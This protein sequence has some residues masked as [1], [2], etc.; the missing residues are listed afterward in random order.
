MKNKQLTFLFLL[1]LAIS[2]AISAAAEDRKGP[3]G[4]GHGPQLTDAQKTCL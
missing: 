4:G 1:S 2:V 3:P